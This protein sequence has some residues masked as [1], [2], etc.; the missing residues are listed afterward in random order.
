MLEKC[1]TAAYQRE[2]RPNMIIHGLIEKKEEKREDLKTAITVFFKEV[3]EIEMEIE[4]N[5]F[6]LNGKWE[7]KT[8]YD[9]IT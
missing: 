1:V 3:M 5:D 7:D 8:S 6:F 9:K 2:I 4:L